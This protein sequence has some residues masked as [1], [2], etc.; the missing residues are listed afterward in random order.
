MLKRKT[1]LAVFNFWRKPKLEFGD[2]FNTY[3]RWLL[4]VKDASPETIRTKRYQLGP[5]ARFVG[6]PMNLIT[7]EDVCLY[8]I[9]ERKRG[10]SECSIFQYL[11]AI[12][13]FFNW[14]LEYEENDE[15]GR[16]RRAYPKIKINPTL[17][18]KKNFP[19]PKKEY[20]P[21][22]TPRYLRQK[23]LE[24]CM[25]DRDYLLVEVKS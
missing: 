10:Q 21:V 14:A 5:F 19:K 17:K 12:G 3:T 25:Y 6:K 20:V 4:E 7:D 22:E 15:R 23:L 1:I 18:A 13:A 24:V 2:I 8:L 9:A 11:I 16:P